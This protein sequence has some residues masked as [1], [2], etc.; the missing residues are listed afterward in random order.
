[1]ARPGQV[2]LAYAGTGDERDGAEQAA[3]AA[4]AGDAD[5]VGMVKYAD[6]ARPVLKRASASRDAGR[7]RV[8]RRCTAEQAVGVRSFSH[9][10]AIGP[11]A[12][13]GGKCGARRRRGARRR[14]GPSLD[15]D[16]QRRD[17]GGDRRVPQDR[18]HAWG[19]VEVLANDVPTGPGRTSRAIAARRPAAGALMG[20]EAIK[21]VEV[22]D[23]FG[24]RGGVGSRPMTRSCATTMGIIV[25]YEPG[26]R[27][28]GRHAQR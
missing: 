6:D 25:A 17:G 3:D 5:L 21:G 20:I 26:G 19:V 11:S 9:V 15:A 13:E 12:P 4:A 22:G 14:S 18:R 7:A 27:H 2:T 28:R 23:G 1:M 24:P 16:D 10:V 8:G